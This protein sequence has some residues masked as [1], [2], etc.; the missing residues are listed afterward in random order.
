MIDIPNSRILKSKKF[1][2]KNAHTL[3]NNALR[4][5]KKIGSSKSKTLIVVPDGT[6]CAHLGTILPRLRKRLNGEAE[7]I[8]A[9]G[10]HRPPTQSELSDLA[11][12]TFKTR[13][14]SQRKADL[15]CLDKRVPIWLNKKVLE[16]D[17]VVS[18][19]T[20]EPHLY[21]GYSGGAKTIAIGLAG[22]P[23]ISFTHHP[24]FLDHSGVKLG[25]V[26]GNPFQ[27]MLWRIVRNLPFS[28]AINIINDQEGRPIRIFAGAPKE[29]FKKGTDLAEKVFKVEAGEQRDLVVCEVGYPKD[30]NLYQASRAINHVVNVSRPVVKKGGSIVIVADLPEGIGKGMGEERF[31]KVLR[32]A[33]TAK[34]LTAGFKTKGCLAGE[35]RAYMVAKALGYANVIFAGK[36][37]PDCTKGINI[38]K[39]IPAS[40]LY[41]AI[42]G[43]AAAYV[44]PHILSAIPVAG[45]TRNN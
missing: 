25:K 24:R 20:I 9:T 27:D 35:H 7:V 43:K 8:V 39:G 37:A 13:V 38:I 15:I 28:L 22:E 45:L 16:A 3:I 17:H 32:S 4:G 1:H 18:I 6:R 33:K 41:D 5:V 19:G 40:S 26:D 14:H 31:G 11:G 21:A 12:K 36:N 2:T 34:E 10:L 44:I 30:V 42:S 23:T 29:V